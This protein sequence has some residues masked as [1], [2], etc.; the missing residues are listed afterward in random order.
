METGFRATTSLADFA[1]R[2]GKETKA[3]SRCV[4][5]LACGLVDPVTVGIVTHADYVGRRG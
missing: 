2:E 5:D 1:V 3:V 4:L